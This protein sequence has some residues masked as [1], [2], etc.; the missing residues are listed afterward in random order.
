[1]TCPF[2]GGPSH[3]AV[4]CEYT[5][6]FVA[7]HRCTVE[8]WAWVRRWI[9][10]RKGIDFYGAAAKWSSYLSARCETTEQS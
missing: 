7:C 6:T 5:P 10:P 9:K 2:C 1:M 8:F 3:P 4:G